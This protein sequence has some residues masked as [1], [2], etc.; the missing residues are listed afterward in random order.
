MR[1]VLIIWSSR[2]H[3]AFELSSREVDGL[4]YRFALL[5]TLGDHFADGAL[6]EHLRAE[7][8]WR[9]ITGEQGQSIAA[10]R[11]IVQGARRRLFFFPRLEITQ[12]LEW[13]R[14][15]CD[16]E[17]LRRSEAGVW[18]AHVMPEE[19]C[20]FVKGGQSAVGNAN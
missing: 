20:S 10:G 17:R 9:G 6:S 15:H 12:L 13:E 2:P 14:G 19:G 18:H 1:S 4:V 11:I 3:K 8:C 7:A 16:R 5:R